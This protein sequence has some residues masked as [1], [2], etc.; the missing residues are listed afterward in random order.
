MRNHGNT[1]RRISREKGTVTLPAKDD[2]RHAVEND[3]QVNGT[4]VAKGA[5]L[6]LPDMLPEV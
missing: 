2:E 1:N 3:L 4:L 5:A 6:E